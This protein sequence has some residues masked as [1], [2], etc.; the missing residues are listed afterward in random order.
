MEHL[1]IWKGVKRKDVPTIKLVVNFPE[2]EA[3]LWTSGISNVAMLCEHNGHKIQTSFRHLFQRMQPHG[4][5][6]KPEW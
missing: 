2:V 4:G 6:T 1:K 3:L 5:C